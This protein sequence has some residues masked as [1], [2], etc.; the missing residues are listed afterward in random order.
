[1]EATNNLAERQLRPAVISRKLSCG[2]K[3]P[4]GA[5]TWAILASLAAT[6]EQRGD[7][8]IEQVAH[9]MVLDNAA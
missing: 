2:N 1:V 8:F 5:T 9:A 6:C 3:T 7:S 4:T